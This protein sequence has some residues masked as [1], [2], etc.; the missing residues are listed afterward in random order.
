MKPAAFRYSCPESL[1]EALEL[2]SDLG[3]DTKILAGGQSLLP[4]LNM[5]LAAPAHLVDING[6]PELADIVAEP[7]GVRVGALA[8]HAQV[9]RDVGAQ[10]VQ[11]LLGQALR[12]VAHPVIRNRGTTVGSLAHADPAGEMTAVLALLDG[13]ME[14]A[15][16]GGRRTVPAAEFFLGPLESC[17]QPDELALSAW[18]PSLPARSGTAFR[19]VA[20]RHGDYAMCGV[21]AAVTL[22]EDGM[23]VRARTAY[24]SMA[25]TPVVL[26]LTDALR[27]FRGDRGDH[28]GWGAAAR[29]AVSELDPEV[30]IHASAAY[31]LQLAQVLTAKALAAAGSAAGASSVESVELPRSAERGR[32]S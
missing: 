32:G 21:A 17:L 3:A 14:V 30:D 20:R 1:E 18:F 13:E 6:L 29:D 8:R 4:M 31:R 16:A 9:E 28:P 23:V 26:D 11:P 7:A 12:L 25:P 24:V 27:G 5:R 19:E 10:V 2:L 15:R 22:D